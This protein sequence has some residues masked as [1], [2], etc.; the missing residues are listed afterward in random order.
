MLGRGRT[1]DA[2][3]VDAAQRGHGGARIDP[4]VLGAAH[5][6]ACNWAAASPVAANAAAPASPTR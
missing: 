5:R 4:D 2:Q 3:I 6:P 1:V